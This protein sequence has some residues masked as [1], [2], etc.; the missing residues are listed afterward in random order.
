MKKNNMP[1]E[2]LSPINGVQTA[3]YLWTLLFFG[4]SMPMNAQIILSGNENKIDLDSGTAVMV[5]HAAPDSIS[6]LDFSQFPPKV[7]HLMDIPNSVIGPPSN[8][9]ITPDGQR[10]LISNSLRANP[11]D[12]SQWVPEHF[13]HVLDLTGTKPRLLG[14]VTTEDQPSGISITPDGTLA[15]VANRATGSITVLKLDST[16]EDTEAVRW[17]ANVQVCEPALSLSD[18]AIAPDGVT[19]LASVQ[20]GGYLAELKIKATGLEPTGRHYSVYGQPYRVVITPDGQYGVTAGAGQ[21]D[22][23]DPDALTI[24]DLQASPPV[25]VDHVTM[26]PVTESLEVSPSGRLIAAVCMSGSNLAM[27][28]PNRSEKG[29]LVILKRTRQGYAVS[30]KLPTGRIPEGV[31]FTSDG[32]YLAVQCHP[33]R[34]IWVYRVRG[35]KVRDTGH[36]IKM[37]GFPSSMRAVIP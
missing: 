22:P 37:P 13:V 10:A 23:L 1:P 7:E 29:S 18:V 25:V 36:R 8:I 35:H 31:A 34:E 2:D 14:Q 16:H 30:Q 26:D 33:S 3:V 15:L 24:I 6:V 21:G 19:V 5:P 11:D 28:D 12:A 17:L 20:K 9:A 4:A 27:D 32:K